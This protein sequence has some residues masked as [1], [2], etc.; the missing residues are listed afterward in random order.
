MN[1]NSKVLN[2]FSRVRLSALDTSPYCWEGD[3]LL[4]GQ[5]PEYSDKLVY[6]F[7]LQITYDAAIKP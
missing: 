3:G 2:S 4:L 5:H 6:D 1:I 7:W